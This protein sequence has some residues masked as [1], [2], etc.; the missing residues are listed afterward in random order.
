MWHLGPIPLRAYALCIIAG[1]IAALVWTDRRFTARGGPAGSVVDIAVFAI[2]AGIIGARL[3][4]V[5]TTPEPYFGS[6]GNLADIPRIWNG[7]L[8]IWGAV[9]GG[10]LGAWYA[11]RRRR[12][13][14][15]VF[16]DALAPA[17][18]L[19]QAFGRWGNYFNQE[20]YG[21]P[22]DTW[23]A[24]EI[25]AAHRMDGY[26]QQA[27]YHPTFLYESLW[28]LGVA[29]LVWWVDR[30]FRLGNGRV[31]AL[32]VMAYVTGRAWIESLRIDPAEEFLGLRLN[33]WTSLVVFL[34]ALAWFVTHK[35]P[36]E[37]LIERPDGTVGVEYEKVRPAS[38]ANV[39]TAGA[40]A[41]P[42]R[43]EG[44]AAEPVKPDSADKQADTEDKSAP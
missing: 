33:I 6:D 19:A 42:N 4:H 44:D 14:L 11:C 28:C 18:A 38:S 21:R 32:Y 27:T 24:V 20:L 35:G 34:G 2:P 12:I 41:E 1:V 15:R 8:G 25:D 26:A 22:L 5:I 43:A 10:A 17:L 31:F 23:W 39:Q 7:G 37:H 3:Y 16:G 40:S 13:P 9:L 29:A 30:R 36:R